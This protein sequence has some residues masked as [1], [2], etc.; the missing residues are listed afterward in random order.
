MKRSLKKI[1]GFG[2]SYRRTNR[3]R[4]LPRQHD[5]H[6]GRPRKSAAIAT[7]VSAD[8]RGR[9]NA[10]SSTEIRGRPRPLPWQISEARQIP[11]RSA[12]VRDDCHRCFRRLPQKSKTQHVPR[13]S[14]AVRGHCHGNYPTRDKYDR[15]PRKSAAITTAGCIR[16]LR[17]F[18][19]V[20]P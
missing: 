4:P 6:H 1:D 18:P 13:T 5:N 9:P 14:A 12:E 20:F 17:M 7:A 15:R 19:W 16:A 2:G 8:F 3:P 10:A 11:R